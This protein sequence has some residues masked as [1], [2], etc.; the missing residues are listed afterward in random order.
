M[1]FYYS[2]EYSHTMAK[3]FNVTLRSDVPAAAD[4]HLDRLKTYRVTL[5][6]LGTGVPEV[7]AKWRET[8]NV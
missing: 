3:T 4:I 7:V 6:R 1:N 8:F 5:D 2:R